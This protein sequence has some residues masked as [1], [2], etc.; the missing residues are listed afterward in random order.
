M[1]AIHA[2]AAVL[3]IAAHATASNAQTCTNTV[4]NMTMCP[5][6]NG[7]TT[8][9]SA[10]EVAYY[11]EQMKTLIPYIYTQMAMQTH[12]TNTSLCT[13]HIHAYA[14]AQAA[15]THDMF[16]PCFS[17]AQP[18]KPC[19]NDCQRVQACLPPDTPS[20]CGSDDGLRAA[21][22]ACIGAAD[23]TPTTPAATTPAATTPAATTPATTPTP[24]TPAATTPAPPPQTSAAHIRTAPY[25][26]LLVF[27]VHY[28]CQ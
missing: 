12:P 10:V 2:L 14:C 5:M 6:L 21:N 18:L 1:R 4:Q 13:A 3:L 24:T 22:R 28:M 8:N 17:K 27:F 19:Y 16:Q 23:P 9:A 26:T 20:I 11:D 15:S 7:L 25:A